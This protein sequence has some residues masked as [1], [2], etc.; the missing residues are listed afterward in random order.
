MKYTNTH[1]HNKKPTKQQIISTLIKTYCYAS[2]MGQ[3][4]NMDLVGEFIDRYKS[5]TLTREDNK[6]LPLIIR[7]VAI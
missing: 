1:T 2:E 6:I 4:D 3:Y 5:N 7:R